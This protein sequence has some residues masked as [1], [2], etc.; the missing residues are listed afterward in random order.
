MGFLAFKVS[1]QVRQTSVM[2]NFMPLLGHREALDD[3]LMFLP[4]IASDY[5]EKSVVKD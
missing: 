4:G 1:E 2:N 5:G 3:L